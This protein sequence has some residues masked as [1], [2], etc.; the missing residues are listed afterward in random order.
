MEYQDKTLK[1]LECQQDFVFCAGEQKFFTEKGF[2]NL[3][4]RCK[5][6]KQKAKSNGNKIGPI[7]TQTVCA[8]CGKEAVVPFVP[9]QGR[10]VFCRDCLPQRQTLQ[11]R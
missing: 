10:P 11:T 7:F 9:T 1:C 2:T 6:C 5:Q 8:S 3:P 4:K